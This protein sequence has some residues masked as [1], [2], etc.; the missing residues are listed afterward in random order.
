V[1]RVRRESIRSDLVDN[2]PRVFERYPIC[3]AYLFGSYATG[4]V[5]PFSDID[6]GIYVPEMSADKFLDLEMKIS[7]ELDDALACGDQTDVRILNN[8]PLS[9]LGQVVTDGILIYSVDDDRRVDFET[10]VRMAYFDF[11]PVIR[12]Y[13]R[14]YVE[15]ALTF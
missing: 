8:L 6:V 5:H 7:L 15:A 2:A 14:E 10:S 13:H 1:I 12:A 4:A 11:L 3:F 9:F